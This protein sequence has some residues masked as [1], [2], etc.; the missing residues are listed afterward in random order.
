[1][2]DFS[3]DTIFKL[4]PISADEGHKAIEMMLVEGE[5]VVSAF[6]TIRDKV[7]ITNKRVI[8]MNV[9]GITGKKIDYTSLPFSKVQA[10]S[11]ETAGTLD[12]DCEID[13]WFSGLGKVRLEIA[14]SFDIQAF[15][16][17]L[18]HYIL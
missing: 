1:M 3:T 10:F 6:S 5:E 2:I 13:L 18:S 7:I 17:I 9:Q 12:R 14:G 11:V 8:T 15:N 4:K 16:R